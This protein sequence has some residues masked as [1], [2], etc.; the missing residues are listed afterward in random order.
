MQTIYGHL[1]QAFVG[2]ADS[3]TAG[4]PIGITGAT[5][6][7]TGEHLHFAVRY[8]GRFI[9]PVQFFRLLLR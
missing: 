2:G 6:R 1:S 3:V 4:Q 7:I 8:R 5:G 9:N